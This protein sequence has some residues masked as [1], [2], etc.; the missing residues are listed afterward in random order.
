ML[1]ATRS[2]ETR[3]ALWD[4]IDLG[5]RGTGALGQRMGLLERV[6]HIGD[7]D[8][9]EGEE[10]LPL[11]PGVHAVVG[12]KVH[13]VVDCHKILR[14]DG[15]TEGTILTDIRVGANSSSPSLLTNSNGQLVFTADN[16][17]GGTQL[18]QYDTVNRAGPTKLTTASTSFGAFTVLAQRLFL[19][20]G[21]ATNGIE[22]YLFD[23][24]PDAPLIT[25]YSP[26][27]GLTGFPA[28]FSDRISRPSSLASQFTFTGKANGAQ[29]IQLF[30]SDGVTT[31]GSA[32][33]AA[34]D[35]SWTITGISLN[36]DGVRNIKAKAT[37]NA[38]RAIGMTLDLTVVR[39]QWLL[40]IGLVVGVMVAADAAGACVA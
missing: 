1:T 22:P 10:L 12:G 6:V 28:T 38:T 9:L 33:T 3:G 26:D 31:L 16:G 27:Q 21:D 23:P 8:E 13:L 35:G 30:D 11:R 37:D 4:E 2:G 29:S 34:A 17:T 25:G 36:G 24:V 32:V 40:V 39:D 15:T 19:A 18:F 20:I 7:E 5:I 14:T